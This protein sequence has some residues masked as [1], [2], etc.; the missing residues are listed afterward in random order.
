MKAV[1]ITL[2]AGLLLFGCTGCGLFKSC[3]VDRERLMNTTAEIN[4]SVSGLEPEVS[5]AIEAMDSNEYGVA[6]TRLGSARSEL[7]SM[8]A[9]INQSCA[10]VRDANDACFD[11]ATQRQEL[12]ENCSMMEDLSAQCVPKLFDALDSTVTFSELV[13][14]LVGEETLTETD[15]G[16]LEGQC[17]QVNNRTMDATASCSAVY[18]RHPGL[19]EDEEFI[20]EFEPFDCSIFRGLR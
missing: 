12:L 5:A 14:E 17:N 11:D 20:G 2:L 7:A 18:S 16:R 4:A 15:I 19:A 6:R 1:A 3:N 8:Q 9:Q 13:D 10:I